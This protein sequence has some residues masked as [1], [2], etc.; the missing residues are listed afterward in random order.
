MNT[1]TTGFGPEK[2]YVGGGQ[3]HIY[4]RRTRPLVREGA[5]QKQDRNCQRVITVWGSTPRL[6]AFYFSVLRSVETQRMFCFLI[7][8]SEPASR[9]IRQF[10]FPATDIWNCVLCVIA[11]WVSPEI[12]RLF[13]CAR[14]HGSK[15]TVQ[16][17][18]RNPYFVP[19]WWIRMQSACESAGFVPT[20]NC[21]EKLE[22]GQNLSLSIIIRKDNVINYSKS[23]VT[24]RDSAVDILTAYRLDGRGSIP[25]RGK[26]F[27]CTTQRRDRFWGPP[28]LISNGYRGLY[29][30]G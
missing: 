20:S 18:I 27:F 11:K 19:T 28:N 7:I 26:R 10:L 8:Y 21:L 23:E 24:S 3:Q 2:Y 29:P 13:V 9:Q 25:G 16:H 15:N 5:P 22:A 12:P 14:A 6:A 1:S 30:K 17:I 4:K